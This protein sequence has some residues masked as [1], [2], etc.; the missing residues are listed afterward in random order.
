MTSEREKNIN[1][2]RPMSAVYFENGYF[3]LFYWP[4]THVVVI[5]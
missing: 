4:I 2:S 3:N 5:F 1:E